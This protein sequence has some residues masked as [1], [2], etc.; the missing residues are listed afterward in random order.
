MNFLSLGK[1]EPSLTMTLLMDDHEAYRATFYGAVAGSTP[2]VV[3]VPGSVKISLVHS[4]T[5]GH[6]LT[7]TM[8]KV[9]LQADP[10]QPDPAAGP[11]L[12]TINGSIE[13]PAAG[14]HVKPVVTNAITTT[15]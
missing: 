2:S 8:D 10:P 15:Y 9:I 3:R 5:A 11:L 7:F 13:K 14:D 6:A 1:I 4:V 12:V